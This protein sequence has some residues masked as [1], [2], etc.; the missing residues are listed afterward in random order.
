MSLGFLLIFLVIVL[1]LGL[2][3]LAKIIVS[4][5]SLNRSQ[6]EIANQTKESILF[7]PILNP[8]PEA[9]NSAKIKISGFALENSSVVLVVNG[10]T[11]KKTKTDNWG[12]FEETINIEAGENTIKAKTVKDEKES[13][14]SDE[15]T[16]KYLNK[17]PKLDITTPENNQEFS[18]VEKEITISGKTDSGNQLFINSRLIII[19]STGEFDYGIKLKQGENKFEI[20]AIDKAGNETYKEIKV[21]YEE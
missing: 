4:F 11:V 16:I 10:A 21:T 5:S 18:G 3:L 17:P 9:T 13:G 19:A 2:P 20:K 6:A 7:A 1:Y 12:K 14:Y 8:L 15:I